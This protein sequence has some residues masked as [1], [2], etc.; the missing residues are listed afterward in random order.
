MS[1]LHATAPYRRDEL[2]SLRV[3]VVLPVVE[4]SVDDDG[5]LDLQLDREPYSADGS[6]HRA[7]LQRVL[8]SIAADLGTPVRVEVHELNGTTFTDIVAP[9]RRGRS[10]ELRGSRRIQT[11]RTSGGEVSGEGF[12][13][14]EEVTVAVVVARHVAG[15]DGTTRLRLPPALLAAHPGLVVLMGQTSGVVLVSGDSP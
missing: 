1:M 4:V 2:P 11:A 3:P 8:D 12:I 5:C 14:D 15:H 9:D 13:P 10:Q 6:L 7:D